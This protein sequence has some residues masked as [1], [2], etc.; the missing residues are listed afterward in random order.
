MS[1]CFVMQP[2]DGG[3]FDKRYKEVIKPGIEAATLEPYRV[4][5]DPAVAIPID[6][7]EQGIRDSRVCL[8]DITT[9][10]PNVWFELGYAI[11]SRKEVVLICSEDR[12]SP[13]PFDVQHRHII[14][15]KTE[16]PQDFTALQESITKKLQ[17]ILRKDEHLSKVSSPI[18][19]VE[20]L[21]Q[22]ETVALVSLA[23]NLEGP[24]DLVSQHAIR[25]DME[26]AGFT[27]VATFIALTLLLEKRLIASFEEE[28]FNGNSYVTYRI[29]NEGTG[30]LMDNQQRLVLWEDPE[31]TSA[32]TD[33]DIPF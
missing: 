17:A 27:R 2:F 5:E 31:K 29:T 10:N 24:E 4:D 11:A 8:A 19:D 9:D 16:A 15:Y 32:P 22:H 3:P 12:H 30:W 26:R 6:D 1:T 23:E 25:K 14:K 18:A 13:F 33:D 21:S 28:D 7:I 20:G